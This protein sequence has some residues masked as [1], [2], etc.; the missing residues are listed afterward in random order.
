MNMFLQSVDTV[1]GGSFTPYNIACQRLT[2]RS[3]AGAA[4]QSRKLG[5]QFFNLFQLLN[6]FNNIAAQIVNGT[7]ASQ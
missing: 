6:A 5:G 1:V 4:V 2:G 7:G 3:A